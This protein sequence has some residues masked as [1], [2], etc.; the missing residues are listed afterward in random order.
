MTPTGYKRKSS[1]KVTE[2]TQ[3]KRL[4]AYKRQPDLYFAHVW[5]DKDIYNQVLAYIGGKVT[6]NTA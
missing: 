4:P 6:R 5:L 2:T 1:I 3:N